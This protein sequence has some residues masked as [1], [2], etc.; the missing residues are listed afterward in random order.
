MDHG[1]CSLW[2]HSF[3]GSFLRPVG[4]LMV[5]LGGLSTAP[6]SGSGPEVIVDFF[7]IL[8][9]TSR[10][11]PRPRATLT[12][13]GI[14]ELPYSTGI[15]GASPRGDQTDLGASIPSFGLV[16]KDTGLV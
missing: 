6:P 11:A 16:G 13:L 15:P 9:L 2:F 12:P 5:S 8:R 7:L 3:P 4:F 10:V 14:N 1:A